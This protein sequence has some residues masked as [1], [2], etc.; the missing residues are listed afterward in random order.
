MTVSH[1]TSVTAVEECRKRVPRVITAESVRFE[2]NPRPIV[3]WKSRPLRVD[4]CGRIPWNRSGKR[5]SGSDIHTF[6]FLF[7]LELGECATL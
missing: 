3:C 7:G 1:C 4:F 5:P 6:L 2:W